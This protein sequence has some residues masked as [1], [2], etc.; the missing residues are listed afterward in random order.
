M[1]MAKS[2]SGMNPQSAPFPPNKYERFWVLPLPQRWI[3]GAHNNF[4]NPTSNVFLYSFIH[5]YSDI[6][7]IW[8][9]I[10]FNM[11]RMFQKAQGKKRYI[12]L[13]PG[14]IEGF[15]FQLFIMSVVTEK[16]NCNFRRYMLSI[17]I[18]SIL[19][20]HEKGFRSLGT[21]RGMVHST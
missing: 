7:A 8:K 2:R 6:N 10:H 14:S 20:S 12:Q 21:A 9:S 15:F 13:G 11:I 18:I 1:S 5:T 3:L 16:L 17:V 4:L 19:V